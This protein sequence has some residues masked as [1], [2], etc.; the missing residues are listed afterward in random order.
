MFPT[1]PEHTTGAFYCW[2]VPVYELAKRDDGDEVL[3]IIHNE[4]PRN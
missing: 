4:F 2:C 3:L 1:F